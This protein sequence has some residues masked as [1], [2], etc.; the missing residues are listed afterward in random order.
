MRKTAGSGSAKNE[1]GS[2]ALRAGGFGATGRG[3]RRRSLRGVG[4]LAGGLA[5]S[6]EGPVPRVHEPL[7]PH[8]HTPVQGS[9]VAV[10]W[11]I[12][13]DIS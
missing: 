12:R 4:G 6:P 7:R 8:A 2:T 3:R 11:G 1:C 10:A 9:N 5:R 13:E